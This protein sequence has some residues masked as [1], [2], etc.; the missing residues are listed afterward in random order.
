MIYELFAIGSIWFWITLAIGFLILSTAAGTEESRWPVIWTVVIGGFL[1]AFS[2]L[3]TWSLFDNPIDWVIGVAAYLLIGS[4][5]SIYKWRRLVHQIRKFCDEWEPGRDW[6]SRDVPL[7][8]INRKVAS[9]FKPNNADYSVEI[10]PR[11]SQF[12]TRIETWIGFWPASVTSG[13]FSRTLPWV[14]D[15][16]GDVVSGIAR[17]LGSIFS[18]ISGNAF[19]DYEPKGPK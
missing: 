16:L 15:R 3:G 7:D 4:V 13:I 10:P 5:W 11:A 1:M 17:L 12:R 6:S 19:E 2:D 14:F 8:L 9:Q 18:R